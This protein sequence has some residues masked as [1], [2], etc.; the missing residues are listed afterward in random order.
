MWM[1]E[2]YTMNITNP[3]NSFST[4]ITEV[5]NREGFPYLYFLFLK[6]LHT[7]L[8]Y[9]PIVARGLSALFGVLSVFAIFKLGEKLYDK[10]AGFYAALL[11]TFSEYAIYISQD[12]R[13]YT[14]YLFGVIMSYYGMVTFLKEVNRKNAIQYGLLAGLLLNFNF[15]ALINLF[16]Q[17]ILVVFYLFFIDKQKRIELIKNGLLS[18]GIAIILFLPNIY[19]LKTLMAFKSSWIPAPGPDSLTIILKEFI[20]N[21]EMTLFMLTPIFIFF[22][23]NVFNSKETKSVS[24]FLNNK[25]VFA[26]IVLFSWTLVY[27]T[28]VFLKSY[29]D[30]SLYIARYFTSIIPVIILVLGIGLSMIKNKFIRISFTLSLVMFVFLNHTIVRNYYKWPNKTQFREAAQLII[31]NNPKNETV[32]TGLKYWF[33]YYLNNKMIRT[34]VIEKP[35][36]EA[37]I[38]EMMADPTK[39]KP[40]WYTDAHGRPFALTEAAQ[41]FV[42]N[43]FYIDNNF[44]GF[45]AWTRHFT[46]LKD[47]PR[48]IDISKF[49]PLQ[50][51][52]GDGFAYNIEAFENTNGI[53]KISGWA[54]FDG[55]SASESVLDVV[56]LKD[57]KATRMLTQKVNRPDVTSYF[58]SSFDLANSGFSSMLNLSDLNK[59]EYKIG[60]YL[61]NK[62]TGKTGLNITDKIVVK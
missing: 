58:K 10:K 45:D 28:I 16:A 12:A 50:T 32:Y 48:S 25:K 20:G 35:N 61:V 21:S 40:F 19:K 23:L 3:D 30:T 43:T 49:I 60:I 46:L 34:N 62:K 8:G 4:I 42:N 1:D 22:L 15:F 2:I 24:D 56:L 53:V 47:V 51:Y 39:V 29:L 44:D 9:S 41:L 31:D 37:V 11:L 55:Q 7:F 52:N 33:D 59:G 18:S 57:G 36:L 26:F 54:Y 6:I 14:I 5:N 27:V 38:S 13:P 17:A